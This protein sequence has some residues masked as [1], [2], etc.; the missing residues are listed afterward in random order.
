MVITTVQLHSANPEL[1]LY[2][3]SNPTRSVSEIRDGG[4]LWQWPRLE[5]SLRVF[6]RSTI[7]Q[8]QFIMIIIIKFLFYRPGGPH[9]I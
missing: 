3:G 4:D 6:P 8:K 2:A 9:G 5:I 7:P 1:R